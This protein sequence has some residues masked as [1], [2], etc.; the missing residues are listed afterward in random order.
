MRNIF[1][2]SDRSSRNANLLSFICLS[3]HSFKPSLSGAL[4]RYHFGS[5]SL[6]KHSESI[7]QALREQS[8]CVISSA[9][10]PKILRLLD[11]I[12]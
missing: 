6:Q 2:G 10:E 9:S 12:V 5:D 7:K 8:D 1:F 3:V 11:D 4:N